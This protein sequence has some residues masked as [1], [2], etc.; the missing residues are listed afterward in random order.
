MKK[1]EILQLLENYLE[2]INLEDDGMNFE[3]AVEEILFHHNLLKGSGLHENEDLSSD[4]CYD[5]AMESDDLPEKMEYLNRAV[6]LDPMNLEARAEKIHLES[7]DSLSELEE[8]GKLAQFA[9]EM[10]KKN[11]IVEDDDEGSYYGIPETRPYIRL[12]FRRLRLYLD[13]G[14][15]N[16]AEK[17]AMD[18]LRLNEMDNLGVRFTLGCIYAFQENREKLEKLDEIYPQESISTKLIDAVL[19]YKEGRVEALQEKLKEIFELDDRFADQVDCID[20]DGIEEYLD[21]QEELPFYRPN[22]IEELSLLMLH[23]RFLFRGIEPFYEYA[24]IFLTETY[25]LF[26]D[27]MMDDE[28][29]EDYK[30]IPF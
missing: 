10:L 13:C 2:D 26:D 14:M 12:R 5:R 3:T 25:G 27:E 19:L 18:I 9:E 4:E 16:K 8:L 1:E 28:D 21:V 29:E 11:H 6:R 23:N 22:S 7:E 15:M 30:D 24:S 20:Y 17:E